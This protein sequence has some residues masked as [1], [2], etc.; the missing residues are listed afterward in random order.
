[1]H[2]YKKRRKRNS[3]H[4]PRK[5]KK[6]GRERL[7]INKF[8]SKPSTTNKEEHQISKAS[9]SDFDLSRSLLDLLK[10]RGFERPTEIQE[11]AI[12][13]I[14]EG[15]DLIGIAGTG[16]GK[17]VAFLLPLIRELMVKAE[18]QSI[19]VVTPTRE[20]ATQVKDEFKMLTRG[21][22][23]Y[24]STLIGGISV[25]L[26]IQDLQR[27]NHI[28]IGTPG[29]ILDMAHQ[30]HLK[31]EKFKT[32][33]LDEFD[34]MLDMGFIDDVRMI[35]SGMENKDQTLLF[36]ATMGGSIKKL[37]QEFTSDPMEVRTKTSTH[38]T[39][40]IHQDVLRVPKGESKI[41]ALHNLLQVQR[42]EKVLLFCETKRLVDKVHKG[43]KE[44]NFKSEL[45]HGDKPQ[46]ARD[47]AL[48]KFKS[49][50]TNVLV[51]TDVVARG[52]DVKDI[53]LVINYD[54]P[55]KYEDYIHRIGRTGRAGKTGK[56]ITFID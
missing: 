40:A 8:I 14:M 16:T 21:L 19:L 23:L 46:K 51:A 41:K 31:L 9:F 6:Q 44:A 4:P 56:A 39:D 33:V 15:R 35:D 47:I 32:L 42:K 37:V 53:S 34:R 13:H 2:N 45:I 7:D 22:G 36:S 29:R 1:M 48:R 17:T 54:A 38:N 30:G 10:N 49:G 5:R 43:L 27:T 28:I 18:D 20:L 3:S 50:R 25:R 12:P 24:Y 26:S 55:R 11:K 52:I